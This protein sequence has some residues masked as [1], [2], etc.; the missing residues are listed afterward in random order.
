[1]AQTNGKQSP[2]LLWAAVDRQVALAWL[3]FPYTIVFKVYFQ[4][5]DLFSVSSRLYL[6]TYQQDRLTTMKV[7]KWFRFIKI[8]IKQNHCIIEI[9]I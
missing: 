3:F 1:M 8:I 5:I 7:R 2:L 4:L 9:D 6:I